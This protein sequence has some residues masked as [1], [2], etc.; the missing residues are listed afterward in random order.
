M[1]KLRKGKGFRKGLIEIFTLLLSCRGIFIFRS[2]F[3]QKN[4][5]YNKKNI[6]IKM[7]YGNIRR[8]VCTTNVI[9]MFTFH[10]VMIASPS[11]L[12]LIMRGLKWDKLYL[13][14]ALV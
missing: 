1:R 2:E 8:F 3:P 9:R 7:D 13:K 6:L 10:P 11:L 5:N 14:I 12:I 4:I